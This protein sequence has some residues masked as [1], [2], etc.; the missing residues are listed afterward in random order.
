MALDLTNYPFYIT[1]K[2]KFDIIDETLNEVT[3]DSKETNLVYARV[4]SNGNNFE[5][6]ND[7]QLSLLINKDKEETNIEQTDNIEV[8]NTV[9]GEIKF[10]LQALEKGKYNIRLKISYKD[11]ILI[12]NNVVFNIE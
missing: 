10:I 7:W 5:I 6:S 3:I 8:Y 1:T 12:S 11:S 9:R 4:L 2:L